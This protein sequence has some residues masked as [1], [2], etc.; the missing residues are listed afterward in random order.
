VKHA[1][2]LAILILACVPLAACHH[3][4]DA[5]GPMERAGKSVDRATEKTGDALQKAAEKTGQAAD[6]AVQATGNAFEKAGKKLK[7]EPAP[8]SS[9]PASS[10]APSSAPAPS[11]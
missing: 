10:S 2:H 7:G 5:E 8:S 6:Q 11:K 1:T 9:A 4:R 3:D